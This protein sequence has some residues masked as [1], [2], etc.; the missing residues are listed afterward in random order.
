MAVAVAEPGDEARTH[1]GG[2]PGC[3][4][5]SA[6]RVRIVC[7]MGRLQRRYAFDLQMALVANGPPIGAARRE[8]LEQQRAARAWRTHDDQRLLDR[9]RFPGAHARDAR[10]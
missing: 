10:L 7:A 4:I 1:V 8:T 9:G 6:E 3:R 5:R 2:D